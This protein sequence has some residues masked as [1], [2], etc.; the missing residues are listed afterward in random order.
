MVGLAEQALRD[1]A[2]A[3]AGRAAGDGGAFG[4]ERVVELAVGAEA[5]GVV[6]GQLGEAAA[7]RRGGSVADGERAAL[8]LPLFALALVGVAA[9]VDFDRGAVLAVEGLGDALGDSPDHSPEVRDGFG[10]DLAA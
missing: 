1:G 2:S 10:P 7:T 6:G 4:A 3:A 8:A 5:L 9:D